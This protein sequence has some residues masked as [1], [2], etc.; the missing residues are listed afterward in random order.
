M[1]RTGVVRWF[2]PLLL[3]VTVLRGLYIGVPELVPQEAYYW[4][5]AKHL[6]LSYFDHPPM[7]AW[8]IALSTWLG[9]D[10]TFFVRLP[11]LLFVTGSMVVSFLLARSIFADNR[12]AMAGVVLMNLTLVFNLHG[13]V[14]TPDA[15]LLFFW[16][17]VLLAVHRALDSGRWWW[18]HLAGIFLGLA[19]LSKYT[20]VLLAPLTLLLLLLSATQR[21]WLLSPHPYLGMLWAVVVFAPVLVWNARHDWVS[22]AFQSTRRAGQLDSFRPI[23]L[24]ELLG[25]QL[26]MLTPLLFAGT[27]YAMWLVSVRWWRQRDSRDLFVLVYSLPVLLMFALVSLGSLVKMN[28]PAPAYISGLLVLVVSASRGHRLLSGVWRTTALTLA[29]GMVALL[30]ALP[31]WTSLPLGKANTWTGW[32]QL[33]ERVEQVRN[34]MPGPSFVFSRNHKISSELAFHLGSDE[35]ILTENVFG[36]PARQFAFW[37]DPA[38]YAGWDA[39]LV[40]SDQD[41]IKTA[42]MWQIELRFE[43][44]DAPQAFEIRRGGRRVKTF[45]LLRGYGY[46]GPDPVS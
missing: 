8:S 24:L 16:A 40:Y 44:L 35:P 13:I 6:D 2:W 45:Y 28:W 9:T 12:L 30:Y 42:E 4:L 39:V 46:R 3:T 26:A 10:T 5:F 22:L 27:G 11:A 1:A 43:R 25:T 17:M 32:S 37:T 38:R 14:I 19:M 34:A 23:Y 7:V 36:Q 41:P 20:A 21:R 31:L 33:S 29:L 18:W 15:P